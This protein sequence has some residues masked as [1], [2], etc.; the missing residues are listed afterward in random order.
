MG[1]KKKYSVEKKTGLI[2]MELKK[3][4]IVNMSDECM[5]WT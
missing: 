5:E 2:T 1:P 3:D 4:I